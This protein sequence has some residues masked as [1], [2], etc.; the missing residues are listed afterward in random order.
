MSDAAIAGLILAGGASRRM[1]TPKTL[2]RIGTETFLDRLIGV[3]APICA[4]VIVV[5][6]HDSA[7][8]RQGLERPGGA[9][10]TINP[11]PDRG[12][13][14]SLQCGL[15]KLPSNAPAV[16]F[17]PVDYPSF[18]DT[19]IVRMAEAFSER[20][21]D[22]VIPVYR[23]RK[24]H[25]VCVSRRVVQELLEL[26]CTAQARDVIRQYGE[27]TCFADVDDPGIVADID[28]PDDYAKFLTAQAEGLCYP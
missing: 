1:G 9:T 15:A 28:T 11:D 26:P 7:W 5:L 18:R 17:T 10:F 19:T 27:R 25:P 22:V 12:M 21:F 3:F 8:V 23:G 2:L 6:G 24:G 13:L 14:S 16:I 20:H 4:P